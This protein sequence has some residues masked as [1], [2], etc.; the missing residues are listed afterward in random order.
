MKI[1]NYTMRVATTVSNS[2]FNSHLDMAQYAAQ[3]MRSQLKEAILNEKMETF[4]EEFSTT[5]R[6][7]VVVM[8]P[9][10]FYRIVQEEA[11]ALV[12]RMNYNRME[13]K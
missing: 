11:M 13:V 8:N 2:A 6:M 5:F 4:R 3:Q 12:S 1:D 9:D 7:D 10:E